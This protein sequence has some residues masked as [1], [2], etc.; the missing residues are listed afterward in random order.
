LP[1]ERWYRAGAR[2]SGPSVGLAAWVSVERPWTAADEHSI[3]ELSAEIGSDARHVVE[4]GW[5]VAPGKYGDEAP[6]LFVFSWSHGQPGCY[7]RCGFVPFPGGIAPGTSLEREVGRQIALGLVLVDGNWWAWMGDRWIGHFPASLWAARPFVHAASVQWFGEVYTPRDRPLSAMGSGRRPGE[8]GAASI[9]ALCLVDLE[10]WQCL[11]TE[12]SVEANAPE[13]Y[14][15]ELLPDG[16][17]RYGG[18]AEM[19]RPR[20]PPSSASA[21]RPPA[22]GRSAPSRPR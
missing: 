10:R 12:V 20:Q 11:P 5:R 15:S 6:H 9:R 3:A 8:D 13:L 16:S 2:A 1:P 7:D 14:G 4:V 19:L 17:L 22:T 18:P 21:E